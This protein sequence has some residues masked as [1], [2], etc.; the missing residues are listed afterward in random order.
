M[1]L[2]QNDRTPNNPTVTTTQGGLGAPG[3]FQRSAP[4]VVTT[5]TGHPLG[6]PFTPAN[7]TGDTLVSSE[8]Q[9]KTTQERIVVQ[10]HVDY[11][12][13]NITDQQTD[14]ISGVPVQVTKSIV[15]SIGGVSS[16][17]I[18]AGGSGYTSATA[19]GATPSGGLPAI[20]GTPVISAGAI[21]SIPITD[22]GSG[23]V[24]NDTITIVGN[25]TGASATGVIPSY[26]SIIAGAYIDITPI[27]KWKS[28][29]FA[30][31]IPLDQAALDALAINLPGSMQFPWPNTLLSVQ[32][33]K[34]HGTHTQSAT[35]TFHSVTIGGGFTFN[36]GVAIE[37]AP[38][39][40]SNVL[41]VLKRSFWKGAPTITDTITKIQKSAGNVIVQG[42]SNSDFTTY[43]I[44]DTA[45]GISDDTS[46]GV[47]FA[48][49]SISDCLSNSVGV[50]SSG[51]G[52]ATATMIL[53]VS[54]P[55]VFASNDVVTTDIR[56]TQWRFGVQV[57]EVV[58]LTYP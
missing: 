42:G 53:P 34:D 41:S 44:D 37:M 28:V 18:G 51:S 50:S 23:H 48:S 30:S 47:T 5:Q 22:P 54:S 38:G 24:G 57:M 9:Q 55:L 10:T 1:A 49:I 16:V 8:L 6:E 40:S 11:T 45:Q 12:G 35:G 56:V 15:P 13:L 31:K 14:P 29:Q 26:P 27:D 19:T 3:E 58:K 17:T 2:I 25:G 36:G 39:L 7:A 52:S 20:Y 43:S 46:T 4:A 21:V 33:I 32:L